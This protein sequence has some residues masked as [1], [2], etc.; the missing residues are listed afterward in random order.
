MQERHSCAHM[1]QTKMKGVIISPSGFRPL[2]SRASFQLVG[3]GSPLR[4]PG[5]CAQSVVRLGGLWQCPLRFLGSYPE[6]SD[7]SL[8]MSL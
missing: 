4:L 7:P 2:A 3:P 6:S 5:L 1:L 8:Q